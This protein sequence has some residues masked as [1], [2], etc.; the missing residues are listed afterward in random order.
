MPMVSRAA[1]LKVRKFDFSKASASLK[2][3]IH[4]AELADV[5]R[6]PMLLSVLQGLAE[7]CGV[8]PA[9]LAGAVT[10]PEA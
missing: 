8:C 9:D 3:I 7:P 10:T 6:Q 4:E 1:N 2:N 5:P